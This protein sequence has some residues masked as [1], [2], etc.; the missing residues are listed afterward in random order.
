MTRRIERKYWA[1]GHRV[2]PSGQFLG[3]EGSTPFPNSGS[4]HKNRSFSTEKMCNKFPFVLWH[5][6]P[7]ERHKLC[8]LRLVRILKAKFDDWG[9]FRRTFRSFTRSARKLAGKCLTKWAGLAL[10]C[11]KLPSNVSTDTSELE[12]TASHL[13]SH[14]RKL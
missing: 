2:E 11:E 12:H 13:R 3:P 4:F 1:E 14:L 9:R 6:P 5:L 7:W 8:K 10:K